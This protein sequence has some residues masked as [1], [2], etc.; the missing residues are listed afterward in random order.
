MH[1][2]SIAFFLFNLLLMIPAKGVDIAAQP[3]LLH[4]QRL[5]DAP[6]GLMKLLP[7]QKPYWHVERARVS[8]NTR[9]V[10]V[11]LIRNGYP[12]DSRMLEADG[13]LKDMTF[14]V[15]IQQS[16]WLALRI[17]PSSH[18]NPVFVE[19]GKQPVRASIRSAKWCIESVEKCWTQKKRHIADAEMQDAIADYNH[20]RMTYR[21]ILAESKME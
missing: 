17:F 11:E 2:A 13:S 14:E 16:S 21:K 15:D 10:R 12:V 4:T 19:V 9:Q 5:A 7:H 6:P 20:A 3:L 8:Q 18:T 1:Q